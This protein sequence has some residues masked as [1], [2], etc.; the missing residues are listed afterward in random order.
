MPALRCLKYTVRIYVAYESSAQS[1]ALFD[2]LDFINDC[3]H[4]GETKLR[5][6]C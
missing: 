2:L 6:V 4:L 3:R 5:E 1:D